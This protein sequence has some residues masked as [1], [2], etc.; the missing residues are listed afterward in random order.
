M[1]MLSTAVSAK[2]YLKY[3]QYPL[4]RSETQTLASYLGRANTSAMY[5]VE[6]NRALRASTKKALQ[7]QGVFLVKYIPDR[8]F[9]VYAPKSSKTELGQIAGVTRVMDFQPAYKMQYDVLK[10]LTRVNPRSDRRSW[11]VNIVPSLAQWKGKLFQD[12][13]KMK[14]QVVDPNYKGYYFTAKLNAA[15]IIQLSKDDKVMWIERNTPIE[16]D[17]DNA[18]IQGGSVKLNQTVPEG[19]YGKGI[20]G[21]VME[22]IYPEHQDFQANKFRKGPIGIGDTTGSGHGHATYGIV[23]GDGTGNKAA[24]GLMP[25]GQGYFTSYNQV[26][27]KPGSRYQLVEKLIRQHGVMFQTASWGNSRTKEYTAVSAEMDHMIYH[28]DLPVTQSQS[29]AGDQMS[30]PQA[31]A[32]NVI[33]VGGVFHQDNADPS[34]DMWNRGGSIGPA[35]DGRIKPDVTAYYDKILTTGRTGYTSFGGTSGATPIVAGHVGLIIEMWARGVFTSNLKYPAQTKYIFAN[36]P[37]AS[38]VK[39]LLINGAVQYPFEGINHDKTRVHQ[40]WGFPNVLT[41]FNRRKGMLTVN[42]EHVLKNGEKKT[43]QFTVAENAPLLKATMVYTEPEA[44]PMAAKTLLN[45]LDLTIKDPDGNIYHGNAFLDIKPFSAPGG[46][47]DKLNN[48]E[49]VFVAKPK[50]GVW[51]IEVAGTSIETDAHKGTIEVDADYSLVV[52]Q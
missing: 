5:L 6:F 30:R 15:Q 14:G 34:D 36:R 2:I 51:T 26:I 49:N 41:L 18:L 12:I 42:E 48:V 46:K 1:G 19:F 7:D 32:K 27:R 20:K 39:A 9:M 38:M 24:T 17:M 47:A 23:F 16:Y 3:A 35:A 4:S 31:W 13:T 43:Y 29:N 37:K 40:G 21:H 22:G 10:F 44:A 8:S 25:F 33:S 45:N 50:A 11:R 52:S 28:L